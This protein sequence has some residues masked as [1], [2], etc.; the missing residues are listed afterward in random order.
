M[1]IEDLAVKHNGNAKV[2]EALDRILEG[3]LPMMNP[4]VIVG[5]MG[6]GKSYILK[7]VGEVLGFRQGMQ[8]VKLMRCEEFVN[9]YAEALKADSLANF[10]NRMTM[11]VSA[12]LLDD[13]DYLMERPTA[14]FELTQC[15]ESLMQDHVKI[16][17]TSSVPISYLRKHNTT[18]QFGSK[19]AQGVELTL[20]YPDAESRVAV[21]ADILNRAGESLPRAMIEGLAMS[22]EGDLHCLVGQ[23]HKAILDARL[24]KAKEI[25]E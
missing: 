8:D 12:F 4:V 21:I 15:I 3:N 23:V 11:G 17:L 10:R 5:N 20:S 1:K 19:I 22:V 6:T 7:A 2:I 24:N 25:G 14:A 13:V 16:V 18:K 9:L